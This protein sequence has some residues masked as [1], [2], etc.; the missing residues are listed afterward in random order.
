MQTTHPYLRAYLAGIAL[1]TLFL[2][3]IAAGFTVAVRLLA[4]PI[5]LERAIVFP[6][7]AVP[8]LWGVWNMLH[9]RF[10]RLP[11][12]M[13][14]ALLPLLLIPLGYLLARLLEFS[15]PASVLVMSPVAVAA[16]YLIWKHLVARLNAILGIP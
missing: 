7:A 9:V 5:A 11:L 3:V 6:M 12:G 1:P 10:G 8:N 2:M 14:G 15:P 13:H 4:I 16:Y